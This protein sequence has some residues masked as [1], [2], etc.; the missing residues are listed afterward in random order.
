MSLLTFCIAASSFNKIIVQELE[1]EQR[2]RD[3]CAKF[4]DF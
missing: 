4:E 3:L 2:A 1:P